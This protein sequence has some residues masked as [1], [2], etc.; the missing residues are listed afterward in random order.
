MF[1]EVEVVKSNSVQTHMITYFMYVL[2]HTYLCSHA[3]NFL[4]SVT[5]RQQVFLDNILY[6][7][8][9]RRISEVLSHVLMHTQTHTRMHIHTHT[10]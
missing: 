2:I 10:D 7:L 5:A 3:Q 8:I 4:I 6:V 9:C 1:L